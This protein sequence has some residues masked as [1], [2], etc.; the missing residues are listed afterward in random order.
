MIESLISE[1]EKPNKIKYENKN[2]I[3][4]QSTFRIENSDTSD[5]IN[6]ENQL[7]E[8]K[9]K[10]LK[11]FQQINIEY[12]MSKSKLNKTKKYFVWKYE[13]DLMNF[14]EYDQLIVSI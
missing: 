2:D 8:L 9:N 10:S 13:C 7:I 1:L 5:K 4:P 6:Y 14:D 12:K 3:K 11:C